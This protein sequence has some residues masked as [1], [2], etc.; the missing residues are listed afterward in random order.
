MGTNE[1][2][3][4]AHPP[5]IVAELAPPD[6]FDR[7]LERSLD[8]SFVRNLVRAAS[9]DAGRP[10][11]DPVVFFGPRLVP[12]FEGRRAGRRLLRAVADRPGP[13]RHLG[14]DLAEPLPVAPTGAGA[15]PA[16]PAG[17]RRTSVPAPPTWTPRRCD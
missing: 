1:Q 13:R 12:F 8:L 16:A 17:A 7:R 14:C 3:V 11:I 6:R 2:A 15:W 4:A 10:S 9:A 5:V